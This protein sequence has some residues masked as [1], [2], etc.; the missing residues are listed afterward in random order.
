MKLTFGE[1]V[2]PL[3][4]VLIGFQTLHPFLCSVMNLHEVEAQ[5][6]DC[7]LLC[8]KHV[9][10]MASGLAGVFDSIRADFCQA[11]INGRGPIVGLLA[12][13]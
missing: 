1:L 7:R 5:L 6:R 9:V 10:V 12:R 4:T 11:L 3:G 13:A 8:R 2:A